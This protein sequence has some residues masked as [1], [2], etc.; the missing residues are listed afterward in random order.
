MVALFA[1]LELQNV[2]RLLAA[3]AQELQQRAEHTARVLVSRHVHSLDHQHSLT[4]VQ[5]LYPTVD[6]VPEE[7]G[8]AGRGKPHRHKLRLLLYVPLQIG[9]IE[10]VSGAAALD[11]RHFC[12]NGRRQLGRVLD[13]RPFRLV[14]GLLV[15]LAKG[16]DLPIH[17][18]LRFVGRLFFLRVLQHLPKAL[19]VECS[20][21]T[22][23][24]FHN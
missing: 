9:R 6:D 5:Q 22:L 3:P 11:G 10:D 2:Q 18:Q 8:V 16:A 20:F 21:V 15:P 19:L 1:R 12:M 7:L 23:Q 14:I 13:V 24:L 4:G 17:R